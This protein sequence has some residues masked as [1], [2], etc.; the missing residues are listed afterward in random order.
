MLQVGV[1]LFDYPFSYYMILSKILLWRGY[2][3][4]LPLWVHTTEHNVGAPPFFAN[5]EP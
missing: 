1:E 5:R 2:L 4:I 3:Y